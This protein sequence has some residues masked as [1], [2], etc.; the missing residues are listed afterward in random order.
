MWIVAVLVVCGQTVLL[1]R[2]VQY[3]IGK[4]HDAAREP[5]QYRCEQI[6]HGC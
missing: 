5:A 1:S 2:S 3:W 4:T 6:E